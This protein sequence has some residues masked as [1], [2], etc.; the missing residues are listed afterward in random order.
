MVRVLVGPDLDPAAD[1]AELYAAPADPWLRVNMVQTLDGAATG[2]SGRSGSINNEVDKVVYDQLRALADAVV[3]GA[4][5]ARVEGYTPVDRPTV[6]VS[7]RGH[8]PDLLRGGTPGSVLL[9]TCGSAELLDEARGLLGS[10]HVL[11]LGSHRVDLGVLKQRLAERGL[12]QLVCEGGPHLLRDLVA[13]RAADE[14]CATVVP[15]LVGGA[16]PRILQG[17]PVDVPLELRLLLESEGTL[18]GR[19]TI[20]YEST[21]AEE[22]IRG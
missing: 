14:L 15:R 11:L 2:E 19:W 9:A 13:A 20:P 7:R 21:D 12:T 17:P 22:D 4:G 10:E 8:V 18:L 6:V 16:H 1:L 5:T 3:V